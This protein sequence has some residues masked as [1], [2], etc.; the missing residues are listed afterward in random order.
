M[1]DII[2]LSEQKKEAPFYYSNVFELVMGPYDF[3]FVFGLKT[4]EQAKVKDLGFVTVANVSMSSSQA[5]A[6]AVILKEFLDKY[7]KDFGEIP[8]ESKFKA[9]YDKAFGKQK[10]D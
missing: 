7:E 4:P 3:A 10:D 2:K 5:K 1:A 9:R 8:M 6:V